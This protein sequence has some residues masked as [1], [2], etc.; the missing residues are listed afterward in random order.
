MLPRFTSRIGPVIAWAGMACC[1]IA[2]PAH[3][4]PCGPADLNG[5]GQ[6]DFADYLEFLNQY[7]LG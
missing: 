6:V 3:A 1:W 7:D 5:D 2:S 4:D